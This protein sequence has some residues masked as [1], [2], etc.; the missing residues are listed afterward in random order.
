MTAP[1]AHAGRASVYRLRVYY[2]DTDLAGIVYYANYLKFIERARTEALAE[3]GIDQRALKDEL[4]VVFAVREV[5]AAYLAPARFMDQ[6]VVTTE[7]AALSGARVTLLQDVWR[8]ATPLVKCRVTLAAIGRDGR[9]V[10]L[11]ESARAA[12]A[13]LGAA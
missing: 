3:L 12:L 13:R 10:R 9:A 4:G 8:D 6:L 7:L 11:P 1:D 5:Q 2:E